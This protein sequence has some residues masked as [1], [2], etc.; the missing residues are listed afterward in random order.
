MI[1]ELSI[2]LIVTIK[3]ITGVIFHKIL[4]FPNKIGKHLLSGHGVCSF[5]VIIIIN[6]LSEQGDVTLIYC[7]AV[8][9]TLEKI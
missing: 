6:N 1:V 4:N 8:C 2:T 7:D 5:Y 3:L 9:N